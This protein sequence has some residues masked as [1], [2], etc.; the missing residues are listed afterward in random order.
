[1]KA[2]VTGA[3]GGLG[4]EFAKLLAASKY[5]LVLVARSADKLEANAALLRANHGVNVESVALD[6]SKPN[7]AAELV[8][9]VASCDILINNAGFASNGRFD[10]LDPLRIRDEMMLDVVTLTE[11]TRAY[12]PGMRARGAGRVM[13]VA[14]TAAFLPGPFMAVYYACKAYVLSFSQAIA[15]ELRGTGVTVTCLCPGA[16]ETGFADRANVKGTLL[17]RL[18]KANAASVARAGYDAMMKGR[19]LEVPGLSNKLVAISPKI[20]PRRMLVWVSR[21]AVES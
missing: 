18:P 9:R 11:L 10:E 7:V 13:N 21:K 20:T 2:I 6:L 15:E 16:T 14:S 12:L 17:F 5:D 4:L 3:S 1:M 8:T 19:D